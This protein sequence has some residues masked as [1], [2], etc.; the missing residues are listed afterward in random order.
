M[1]FNLISV[2]ISICVP[3]IKQHFSK[4][5]AFQSKLTESCF[6]NLQNTS[7]QTNLAIM[8]IYIKKIKILLVFCIG[9]VLFS[10]C[11]GPPLSTQVLLNK[12][13]DAASRGEWENALRYLETVTE[14]EPNNTNALVFKA[15]AYEGCEK[16]DLAL[17]AARLAVKN[18]PDNF[19]AQ[20]TLGRLYSKDQQKIQDAITPLG[21]A[22]QIKPD[23][24]NT[25]L[26]L[27]RCA[28]VLKLD[29]AIKYY[30][31][32]AQN[33]K[34][35]K[36][37]ELWNEMGIYYAERQQNRLAAQCFVKAYKLA[38]SKPLIVL[39]FATFRDQYAGDPK[40]ALGF[41]KKYLKIAV[42]SP[43]SETQRKRVKTRIEKINANG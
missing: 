40:G 6:F 33:I 34:F 25:L 30:K 3:I 32:L 23:D 5:N 29:S 35:K 12:A 22:L 38:P 2:L 15:L 36:S 31:Q 21:R 4:F 9:L 27:G 11:G 1:N 20:Y 39:N 24:N 26:L 17:N 42:P 16:D 14:R 8:R 10:G 28:T 19:Q 7:L 37:A 43:N 18:A 41:Y 13:L